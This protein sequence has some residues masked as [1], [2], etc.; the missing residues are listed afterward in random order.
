VEAQRSE[1]SPTRILV[2]ED[3]DL[4]RHL[5]TDMLA[6]G[7]Y[8]TTAVSRG[9]EALEAIKQSP[10]GTYQLALVDLHLPDMHGGELSTHMGDVPVL[11]MS[12][13][14]RDWE[15]QLSSKAFIQK[16]FR[17]RQLLGVVQR[18]LEQ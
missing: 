3:S 5:C 1:I 11:L 17:L 10:S 6:V 12:G 4:V 2:V 8:E 18:T 15:H 9:S 14:Q 7:G 13:N 16:P